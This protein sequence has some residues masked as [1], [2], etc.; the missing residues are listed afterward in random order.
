MHE[1]HV[2][3]AVGLVED[4]VGHR[5]EAHEPLV[6]EIEQA[7]RRRHDD[8]GRVAQRNLLP[9]LVDAAVDDG[10]THRDVAA[11]GRH[12]LGNLRGELTRRREDEDANPR[13]GGR[14]ELLQDRQDERGGLPGAGLGAGEDVAAREDV[15]DDFGLDGRRLL[16][17]L[18]EDGA[19]EGRREAEGGERGRGDGLLGLRG[20]RG[21]TKLS[22]SK[23]LFVGSGR[24]GR[25]MGA[26]RARS[27]GPTRATPRVMEGTH[28]RWS[29]SSRGSVG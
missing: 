20:H 13:A 3:H 17:V 15:R 9:V 10:V 1:A 4:E 16:V 6:D 14:L 28:D 23:R 2:E 8:L 19:D 21:G 27:L 5:V 22:G 24:E 12:A 26:R 29:D 11:V 7:A 25:G 18:V